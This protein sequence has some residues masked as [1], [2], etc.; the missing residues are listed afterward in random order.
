MRHENAILEEAAFFLHFRTDFCLEIW[1]FAG[2][3]CIMRHINDLHAKACHQRDF[4]DQ[5]AA[6]KG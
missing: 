1:S 2:I 5:I 6:E 3:F 4:D